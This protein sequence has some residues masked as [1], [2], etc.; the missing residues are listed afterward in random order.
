MTTPAISLFKRRTARFT[1]RTDARPPWM[2]RPT[3]YGQGLKVLVLG[4]IVVAVGYPFLIALGTSL[5]GK[6]EIAANGGYVMFPT[7]PTLQAYE[8][9]LSGGVVTRAALVSIGVTLVGTALSLLCTIALAYGLSRPGTVAGKPILF[10]VLGT[11]LFTPGIIPVYLVVDQLGMID[12]YASLIVPI[13]LNAFNIV[14][15]RAFFQGIP[16]ELH[17]AARLDGAGE[18]TV[19]CRIVLPLSKAVLAVVGMFYAVSYWNNFFNAMLYI[20]DGAKLPLQMV[21]R[22]YVLQGDTINESAMGVS[23][24]PPSSATQMAV[25]LLAIVPIVAVYPF[26]QRHFTKGVLTGAVKG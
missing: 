22:S 9:V 14:V 13:M 21:L 17:E 23:S 11:F 3:W 8:A 1:A 26:L 2:E 16:D 25:L 6:E 7:E 20:N 24:L 15:V 12:S 18:I 4:A 5:A 10:L 19:L